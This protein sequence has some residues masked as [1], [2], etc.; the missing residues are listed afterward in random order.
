MRF[1]SKGLVIAPPPL[2][3]NN[4]YRKLLLVGCG[5]RRK[6]VYCG[7]CVYT[8]VDTRGSCRLHHVKTASKVVPFPRPVRHSF[9]FVCTRH[10]ISSFADCAR[11]MGWTGLSGL[12]YLF[13]DSTRRAAVFP[14]TPPFLF[15]FF[16]SGKLRFTRSLP[17]SGARLRNWLDEQ[18]SSFDSTARAFAEL[19]VQALVQL[20]SASTCEPTIVTWHSSR[21]LC[22]RRKRRT[23]WTRRHA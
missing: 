7:S 5:S 9:A 20:R 4:V 12:V 6:T 21:S 8:P 13:Q 3:K 15:F 19:G 10:Q 23:S 11:C 1:Q 14:L 17:T 22:A 2:T 18:G 16:N